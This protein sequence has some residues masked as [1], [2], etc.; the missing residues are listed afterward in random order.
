MQDFQK[1]TLDEYNTLHN[2]ITKLCCFLADTKA[3]ESV[4][5]AQFK[6][7]TEQYHAMSLYQFI[8]LDRIKL[9]PEVYKEL[10]N[11]N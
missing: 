5:K 8:L 2:N 3:E 6:L 1:R 10:E 11:D 9:M 7:M 4:G